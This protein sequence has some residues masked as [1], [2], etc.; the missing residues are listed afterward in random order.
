[1]AGDL[2]RMAFYEYDPECPLTVR[3]ANSS[4]ELAMSDLEEDNSAPEADLTSYPTREQCRDA[5][6]RGLLRAQEDEA[7]LGISDRCSGKSCSNSWI[8]CYRLIHTAWLLA[9]R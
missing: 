5:G 9:C 2:L 1:M 7:T 3:K 8:A 4:L 6:E